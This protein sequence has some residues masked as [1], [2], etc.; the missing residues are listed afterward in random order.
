MK[1]K[2]VGVAMGC[3]PSFAI[4]IDPVRFERESLYNAAGAC[5]APDRRK[6]VQTSSEKVCTSHCSDLLADRLAIKEARMLFENTNYDEL[7]EQY[8]KWTVDDINAFRMQFKSFDLNQDGLIDYRE[9][10]QVLDEMG[11][12]SKEEVRQ[13]YFKKVDVDGSGAVDFEEFLVLID[14]VTNSTDSGGLGMMCSR[15]TESVRKLRRLTF[16][17]Q[18]SYGLF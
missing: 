7:I 8:P 18:L 6:S 3:A 14:Q 16:E 10:C 17:Q 15:G 13:E 11:D 2:R 9:L 1:F 12:E 4:V 5:A